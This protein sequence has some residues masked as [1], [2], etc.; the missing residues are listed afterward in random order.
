M[1]TTTL[2]N[3]LRLNI[4]TTLAL[5]SVLMALMLSACGDAATALPAAPA[6]T[7]AAAAAPAATTAAAAAAAA[8]TA[9]S[10]KGWDQFTSPEG[11][12]SILMPSNRERKTQVSTTSAGPIDVI[13]FQGGN[14][15]ASYTVSYADYPEEVVKNAEA[16]AI[17]KGV[18][19][20]Q[21]KGLGGTISGEEKELTLGAVPGRT[22]TF[23]MS[24]GGVGGTAI[25]RVYLAGNRLYQLILIHA[26]SAKPSDADINTFFD[27]FKVNS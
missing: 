19:G 18:L 21:V 23:K 2:R 9:T 4:V 7:T 15:D 1:K 24:S 3:P 27:S 22:A 14:D 13:S 20:G 6:A 16:A 10:P 8:S 12:F 26:D 17:M 5:F 11:K 25:S